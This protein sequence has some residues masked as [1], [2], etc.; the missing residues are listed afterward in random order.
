[1]EG[2]CKE[3]ILQDIAKVE[4]VYVACNLKVTNLTQVLIIPQY[5]RTWEINVFVSTDLWLQG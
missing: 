1:M 3:F 5:T 4:L 2:E